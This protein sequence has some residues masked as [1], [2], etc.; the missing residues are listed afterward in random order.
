MTSMQDWKIQL[1]FTGLVALP[2]GCTTHLGLGIR[3]ERHSFLIKV[4][5]S[6]IR[7]LKQATP[8]FKSWTETR[9]E[10]FAC[11]DISRP[12]LQNVACEAPYCMLTAAQVSISVDVVLWVR[13]R[14]TVGGVEWTNTVNNHYRPYCLLRR[15][16]EHHYSDRWRFLREASQIDT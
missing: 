12:W 2:R 15:R 5:W 13:V 9:S 4:P 8:F 7:E 3:V 6:V 10:H 14:V 11:Q 16:H 1:S